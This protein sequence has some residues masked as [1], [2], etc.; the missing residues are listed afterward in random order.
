M[1][2][3]KGFSPI[4]I[5]L[6]FSIVAAVASGIA[7]YYYSVGQ[8]EVE[9]KQ[10]VEEKERV[11]KQL[12]DLKSDYEKLRVENEQL[13]GTEKAG[14]NKVFTNQEDGYSF[15]YSSTG[16]FVIKDKSEGVVI[17]N[18]KYLSSDGREL[19]NDEVKMTI[20]IKDN[21]EKMTPKAWSTKNIGDE[22]KILLKKD[23]KVDGKSAYKIKTENIGIMTSVYIAKSS[24][25]MVEIVCFGNDKELQLSKILESFKFL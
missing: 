19:I 3:E 1:Y 23:L 17:T 6:I 8:S 2:K 20:N 5:V 16:W 7:V 14:A 25:K 4:L 13:K 11:E 10:K 15:E 24:T 21:T 12:A 22:E 9:K 18:F